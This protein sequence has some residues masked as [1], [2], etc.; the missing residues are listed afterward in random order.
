MIN[1]I[2]VA[3]PYGKA[4]YA[5]AKEEAS[6]DKWE[7]MLHS[8]ATLSLDKEFVSWVASPLFSFERFLK[9]VKNSFEGTVNF[10]ASMESFLRLVCTGA[11]KRFVLMPYILI[12]FEEEKALNSGVKNVAITSAYPLSDKKL[13]D[14]KVLLERKFSSQLHI[15]KTL[16]DQSL[17][18]G[19]VARVDDSVLDYSL[20][21]R[22]K[23][24]QNRLVG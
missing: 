12:V 24:L 16:V 7:V 18:G 19:F 13:A 4:I 17:I 5:V 21:G 14:V 11:N 20:V 1:K 10:S 2:S 9:F 22:V 8:V 6:F 3:R 23:S 15:E